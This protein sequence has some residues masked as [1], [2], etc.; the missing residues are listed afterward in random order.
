[1]AR[2]R[3]MFRRQVAA[4]ENLEGVRNRLRDNVADAL[5]AQRKAHENHTKA[6]RVI[7]RVLAGQAEDGE[8]QSRRKRIRLQDSEDAGGFSNGSK[9][10]AGV[11]TVDTLSLA[12]SQIP[13]PANLFERSA[14]QGFSSLERDIWSARS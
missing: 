13:Q 10:R 5:D 2:Q 12:T 7:D 3:D 14:W 6:L 8:G 4:G 9:F 11:R 1:M